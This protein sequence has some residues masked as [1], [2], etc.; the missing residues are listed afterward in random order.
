M[1]IQALHRRCLHLLIRRQSLW[2]RKRRQKWGVGAPWILLGPWGCGSQRKL[3]EA[4]KR[5]RPDDEE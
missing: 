1:Q 4:R 5:V 2:M 3:G